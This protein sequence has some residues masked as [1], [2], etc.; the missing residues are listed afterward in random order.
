MRIKVLCFGDRK[1]LSSVMSFVRAGE[2]PSAEG[3][4]SAE[5]IMINGK[6]FIIFFIQS[7][8]LITS[9]AAGANGK[10]LII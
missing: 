3:A 4:V 6:L 2:C 5:E 7:I 9:Q 10:N 1:L 8:E